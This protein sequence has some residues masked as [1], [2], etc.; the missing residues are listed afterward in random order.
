M[1]KRFFNRELSWLEFNA[2]VLHEALK[3]NLPL[4]ERINFLSIASNNFNEFFQVRVAS[5]KRLAI[6]NPHNRDASNVLPK[7]LLRQIS[8]RAHEL[9]G[10]QHDCLMNDIIPSLAEAHLVYVTRKEFSVRQKEYAANFFRQEIFPLLTPLVQVQ[11]NFHIFQMANFMP[12]FYWNK[13][14]EY[15]RRYMILQEKAMSLA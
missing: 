13:F 15:A 12:L 6:T 14:L 9:I 11:K 4:M 1:K 10:V 5:V 8:V 7:T 3:K 2:R